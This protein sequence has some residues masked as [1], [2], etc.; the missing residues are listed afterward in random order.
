MKHLKLIITFCFFVMI[1]TASLQAAPGLSTPP[2]DEPVYTELT[3]PGKKIPLDENHYF[4]YE[5]SEK[6]KI[7]FVV[8][9]IQ[10]FDGENKKITPVEITGQYDMPSMSGAHDSGQQA[11]KL[12]KKND[13]LLPINVVMPGEWEIKLIFSKNKTPFFYGHITFDV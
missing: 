1:A 3:K 6:P 2:T 11:F 7:G 9:K 13:Y 4:I 10:V 8:L 12:N 5:F